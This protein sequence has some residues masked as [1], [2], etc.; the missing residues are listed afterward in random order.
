MRL[1][2]LKRLNAERDARLAGDE[3]TDADI[4]ALLASIPQRGN[5]DRTEYDTI[6]RHDDIDRRHE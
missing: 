4:T 2:D 5:L 1:Y 3:P 6:Q